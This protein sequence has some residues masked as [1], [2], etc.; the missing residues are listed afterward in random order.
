[1]FL[2]NRL[3]VFPSVGHFRHTMVLAILKMNEFYGLTQKTSTLGEYYANFVSL[4][5][6]AP[7][8]TLEQ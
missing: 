2:Y 4:R 7:Q 8:M 6:Y 3:D 5:R 1:M